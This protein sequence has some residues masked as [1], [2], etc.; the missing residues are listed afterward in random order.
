MAN[1]INEKSSTKRQIYVTMVTLQTWGSGFAASAP[2]LTGVL[3]K[4]T[5]ASIKELR[6]G[7]WSYVRHVR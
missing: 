4:T 3:G 2:N 6:L 7:I 1:D 5:S